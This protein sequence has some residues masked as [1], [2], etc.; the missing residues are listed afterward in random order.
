M[1]QSLGATYHQ[2]QKTYSANHLALDSQAFIATDR[3][4]G[5]CTSVMK[6]LA[7]FYS[8][9]DFIARADHYVP[10]NYKLLLE[11][12]WRA[13]KVGCI[14]FPQSVLGNLTMKDMDYPNT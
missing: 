6:K 1:N 2:I 7:D 8:Q 13:G 10:V 12:D 5:G 14:R 4:F 3:I 9:Q 11:S